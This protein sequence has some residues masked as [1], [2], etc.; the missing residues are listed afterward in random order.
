M[1]KC[2]RCFTIEYWTKSQQSNGQRQAE[3]WTVWQQ[4]IGQ[5][6]NRVLNS[7]IMQSPTEAEYPACNPNMTHSTVCLVATP[8]YVVESVT[9]EVVVLNHA[10]GRGALSRAPQQSTHPR[11]GL[12]RTRYKTQRYTRR[13]VCVRLTPIHWRTYHA[14]SRHAATH[15]RTHNTEHV[16]I[17]WADFESDLVEMK[18]NSILIL[19]L[20]LSDI[21][22]VHSFTYSCTR[23]VNTNDS[24]SQV[25]TQPSLEQSRLSSVY[26]A[27]MT[28]GRTPV[29]FEVRSTFIETC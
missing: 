22:F 2:E 14:S 1:A 16:Y 27:S 24:S 19:E 26:S 3:Y 17:S 10:G 4:S 8:S 29:K 23:F 5:C 9:A 18:F 21:K 11:W 7:V 15:A 13:P 20:S 12:A 6:H 28:H 25:G